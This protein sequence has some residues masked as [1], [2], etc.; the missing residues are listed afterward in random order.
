M[1]KKI[2]ISKR[3][4]ALLAALDGLATAGRVTAP[5]QL[6][7]LAV[8]WWSLITRGL[9][10]VDRPEVSVNARYCLTIEGREAIGY[11][12]IYTQ[13]LAVELAL[14][15]ADVE[16]IT[17]GLKSKSRN[18]CGTSWSIEDAK[19]I[20]DEYKRLMPIIHPAV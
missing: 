8:T 11:T 15:I 14:T 4:E 1:A 20:R 17:Q 19:K 16:T 6:G 5:S 2:K 18:Q 9:I 10:L 7:H 12:G 13:W 3:Q